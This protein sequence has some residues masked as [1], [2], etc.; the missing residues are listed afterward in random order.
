MS[1]TEIVAT[2]CG[3]TSLFSADK[4]K[5]HV[6]DRQLIRW[7]VSASPQIVF[8]VGGGVFRLLHDKLTIAAYIATR[9]VGTVFIL[10]IMFSD[11]E[12][13]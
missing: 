5:R 2:N 7:L 8:K 4:I 10:V 6:I 13:K 12:S 11:F 9:C 3:G 1:L